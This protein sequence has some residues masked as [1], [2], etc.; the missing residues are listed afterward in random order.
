MK[1]TQIQNKASSVVTRQLRLSRETVR[2]LSSKELTAI[3]S[4]GPSADTNCIT[5][6][7]SCDTCSQPTRDTNC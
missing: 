6:C 4:A 7:G 1:K 2:V 5:E 3:R